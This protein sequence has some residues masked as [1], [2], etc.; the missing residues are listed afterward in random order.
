MRLLDD[1]W[2]E[3]AKLKLLATGEASLYSINMAPVVWNYYPDAHHLYVP[4]VEAFCFVPLSVRSVCRGGMG[5]HRGMA[6]QLVS[7]WRS[8]FKS[9]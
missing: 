9:S 1:G 8:Y 6:E 3:R 5:H 4:D 2:E 7:P